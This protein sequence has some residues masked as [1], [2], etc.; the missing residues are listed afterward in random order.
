LRPP[1][2]AVEWIHQNGVFDV[3]DANIGVRHVMNESASAGVGFDAQAVV[4]AVYRKVAHFDFACPTISLAAYRHS[5]SGIKMVVRDGHVVRGP[6]RSG[7]D[8]ELV[9]A[10]R[11]KAVGYVAMGDERGVD[12]VVVARCLGTVDLYCP[13]REAV[14]PVDEN[15][16]IR[17]VAES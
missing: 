12:A 8:C 16:E 11:N 10:E 17:R 9:M 2:S 7:L 5:V 1:F 6:G 13:C 14:S 15:M 3:S 4:C